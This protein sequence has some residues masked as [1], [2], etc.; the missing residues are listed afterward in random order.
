MERNLKLKEFSYTLKIK[1]VCLDIRYN[2]KHTHYLDTCCVQ[3]Q[4]RQFDAI[5]IIS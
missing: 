2:Y 4:V 5:T 3:H 1:I